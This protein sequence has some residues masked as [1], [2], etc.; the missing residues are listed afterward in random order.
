MPNSSRSTPG[1][2][3]HPLYRRLDEPLGRSG[4]C[5]KSHQGDS[6][7]EPSRAKRVAIPAELSRDKHNVHPTTGHEGP[8]G[9]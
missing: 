7:S 4:G 8:E 2:T 9:E 5:D 1:K 3:R 6:I